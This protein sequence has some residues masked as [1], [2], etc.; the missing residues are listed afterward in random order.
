MELE[1]HL[2]FNLFSEFNVFSS[3]YP[4]F[5]FLMANTFCFL[6]IHQYMFSQQFCSM[7]VMYIVALNFHF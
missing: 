3:Q 5:F 6:D 1:V 4:I 2:L 7:Q